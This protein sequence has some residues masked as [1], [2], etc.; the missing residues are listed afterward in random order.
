MTKIRSG[1]RSK[2]KVIG[3]VAERLKLAIANDNGGQWFLASSHTHTAASLEQRFRQQLVGRALFQ[4]VGA[5]LQGPAPYL[6]VQIAL[7]SD[8]CVGRTEDGEWVWK[9]VTTNAES[10]EWAVVLSLREISVWLIRPIT[11]QDILL[12]TL[13]S[14]PTPTLRSKKRNT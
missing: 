1:G 13:E 8:V 3:L 10:P 9:E 11:L 12:S 7:K 4:R 6:Y 2:R 14:P 5:L